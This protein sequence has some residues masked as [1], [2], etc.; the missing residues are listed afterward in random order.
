MPISKFDLC[1]PEWLELVFAKRNKEYGAYYLRQHYA[2]NMVKAMGITFVSIAGA[3]LITGMLIG[4]K[5]TVK[6]VLHETIVELKDIQP[7]VPPKEEVKKPE[8]AKPAPLVK[9]TKYVTMVVTEQPV[10]EEPPKLVDLQN[11]AIGPANVKGPDLGSVPVII[12]HTEG[13]GTGGTAAVKPDESIHIGADVM[14][15][16]YGGAAGWS[17]FLQRN[18]RYPPEAIDKSMSGKVFVSFVVEKD[19]QISNIKV[20]RGAGYGMDEEAARVL[21]LSKAW[22]PG[23]QNGQPVRVRYTLPISF[24]INQ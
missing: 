15:E 7:P 18:L 11:T 6:A 16:P 14:P 17:K 21:K 1:K 20:D 8:A 3:A 22:K 4:V 19:G 9:T 13:S 12:D 24:A 23:M 2:E 10:T 5:P